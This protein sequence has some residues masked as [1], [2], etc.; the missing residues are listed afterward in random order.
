MNPRSMYAMIRE[1]WEVNVDDKLLTLS[2]CIANKPNHR[3]LLQAV[4]VEEIEAEYKGVT[5]EN[6]G[7][8]Q[9]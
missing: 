5:E 8:N 6:S 4:L 7:E 1:E 3:R 2:T 9:N